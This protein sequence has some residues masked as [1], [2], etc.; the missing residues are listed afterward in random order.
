MVAINGYDSNSGMNLLRHALAAL[1]DGAPYFAR[2]DVTGGHLESVA[3]V[4]A[5]RADLAAIDCVTL[6]LIAD[7]DPGLVARVRV[8]GSSAASA[9]LPFVA[10]RANATGGICAALDAALAAVPAGIR[11]QLRLRG[12]APVTRDD[13][14]PILALEREARDAGYKTLQ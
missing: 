2:V 3:A 10:P 7:A 1:A 4:A 6:R 13:Y 9:G 14:A 12:F 11:E 5:G 8:I